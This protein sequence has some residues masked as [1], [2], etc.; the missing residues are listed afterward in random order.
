MIEIEKSKQRRSRNRSRGKSYTGVGR[1]FV[2]RSRQGEFVSLLGPSGC[3]KSTLLN[4]IAG[5]ERAY[6]DHDPSR[7]ANGSRGRGAG[8]SSRRI[9]GA[10]H[11]IPWLNVLDNVAFGLKQQGMRKKERHARALEQIKSVHLSKFI[12]RYP[13][14]L[15]GGMKQRVAIARALV[16]EPDI[17]LMDEPFAALD[18]QT[19]YIVAEGIGGHMAGTRKTMLFITHNIR[20][21][22]LLS[23]RVLVMSTQPGRI[24]KEFARPGRAAAS[25]RRSASFTITRTRSWRRSRRSWRRSSERR[26]AMT[27]ALRRTLFLIVLIVIWESAYRIFDW[28][29]KFP[30]PM[31]T[32]EAFYDGF[33]NGHLF[34]SIVASMRR[35]LI[36][37]VI[38][39]ILGTGLGFLFARFRFFDETS[40]F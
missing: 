25:S 33:A 12:D 6:A 39:I 3:G 8:Q 31:Q 40:D 29:W 32:L 27:I 23:D 38:S 2:R 26:W 21:A 7:T 11:C 18:E 14:E 15:S 28:G 30:S 36:S 5:F 34:G 1:G 16:M 17:L 10:R 37:F 9:P 13:H 19:R 35:L 24:K 22:V 20:E 4:L